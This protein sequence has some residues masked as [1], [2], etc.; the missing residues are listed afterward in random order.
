MQD[1]AFKEQ[2]EKEYK[3]FALSELLLA[4][5]EEDDM[6]VRKLAKAVGISPSV[7]QKLRSGEQQDLKLTNFVNIAKE[8]GYTLVLEKGENRIRLGG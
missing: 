6:S 7:I 3:E 5:M 1:P 4:M 8:F 2:F